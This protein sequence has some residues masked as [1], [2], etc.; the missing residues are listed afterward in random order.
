M[1]SPL[2]SW[3][4]MVF[5]AGMVLAA[6]FII[7]TAWFPFQ[8]G[9]VAIF[10]TT[11]VI[12]SVLFVS[13]R[14]TRDLVRSHG[15]YLA[16]LVGL[17][18]F[19]YLLSSMAMGTGVVSLTGFAVETDT[20]LFTL[21]LSLAFV[22]SF[23]LF[24]T[25][26]TVR[27]LLSVV[28]WTLV[29]VL[30]FQV[31]VVLFG[32]PFSFF[33]DRSVNLLGKWNDLGL[34][35][36]LLSVFLLVQADIARA[37]LARRVV[38]G[39]GLVVLALLLALIN[40]ALA[41]WFVLFAGLII[42]FTSFLTQRTE[43][44]AERQ[45]NPYA[46]SSWAQRVPWFSGVAVM[47]ALVFLLYG[48]GINQIVSGWFPVTSLE[49]RPSYGSTYDVISKAR[50]G[51]VTKSLVGTGPNTF[52]VSWTTHKPSEVNQSNFYFRKRHSSPR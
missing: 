34:A 8:L 28:M 29:V 48:N 46:T 40:F 16:L 23:G 38:A 11:L 25:L 50:E 47:V 36:V 22:L 44:R 31:V 21:V 4:R 32:L 2:V 7:P 33:S 30:A 37:S 26:R 18:P 52:S 24:K 49:V 41:W 51:S 10:I 17:L 20:V 6:A 5:L 13:G 27:L 1:H 35:A 3:S 9:K 15:V 19:A 14:G 45:S 39:M 43:D 12:T 42:A